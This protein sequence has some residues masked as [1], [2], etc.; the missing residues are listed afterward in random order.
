MFLL[1]ECNKTPNAQLICSVFVQ[2]ATQSIYVQTLPSSVT[3][4][5]EEPANISAQLYCNCIKSLWASV[6]IV[7][8]SPSS[9]HV[10]FYSDEDREK[11]FY[12]NFLQVTP[13]LGY[14]YPWQQT[15]ST[16]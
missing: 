11:Q 7:D 13:L 5:T 9:Q 16:Y 4:K 3:T 6:R 14:L 12:F 8:L 15:S 2:E 10:T 1:G